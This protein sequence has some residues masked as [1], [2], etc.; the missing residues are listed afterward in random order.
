MT[1]IKNG[2]NRRNKHRKVLKLAK[3]FV[4][5]HSK[6]FTAAKQQTMKALRYSYFDRQKKKSKMNSLWI[7]RINVVCNEKKNKFNILIKGIKLNKI[8]INKKMLAKLCIVDKK[9][10]TKLLLEYTI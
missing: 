3:G 2:I 1:R 8:L 7:Q 5:G 10:I 9:I 4:G 6:L